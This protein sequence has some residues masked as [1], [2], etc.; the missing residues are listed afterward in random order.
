[1]EFDTERLRQ[2]IPKGD[3]YNSEFANDLEAA[4]KEIERLACGNEI[5]QLKSFVNNLCEGVFDGGSYDGSDIQEM[6]LNHGLLIKH[7]VYE[8]CETDK[9]CCNCIEF[10]STEE[11]E[12]GVECYRK[13]EFLINE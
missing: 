5:K 13:A 7:I 1:M 11:F 12:L 2:Y 4:A 3:G 9:K 10:C 6:M 8:S